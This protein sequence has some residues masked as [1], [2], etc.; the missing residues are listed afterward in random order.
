MLTLD[1]GIRFLYTGLR[2]KDL[3]KAIEFFTKVLGMKILSRVDAPWNK[4][5]FA[6][7][8]YDDDNHYLELSWYAPDSQ[9]CTEFVAGDQLD[10]LGMKVKD[11]DGTLKRLEDAG[12]P[13][14]IGPIHEGKEH[15]AF[16]EG[17]E[18]IWLDIYKID[19]R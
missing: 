5:V 17:Y 3:D 9:Y 7:L 12:Y 15:I 19:D 13:V 4:G 1:L 6:N 16:V 14:K 8:G 11:F 18:G 2:V 10:H